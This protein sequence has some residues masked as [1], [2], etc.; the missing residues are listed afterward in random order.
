MAQ[1][2][3]DPSSPSSHDRGAAR[4]A[5]R[6]TGDTS[7]AAAL[8]GPGAAARGPYRP[9]APHSRPSPRLRSSSAACV[10]GAP[11]K[12]PTQ[13]STPDAGANARSQ[14]ALYSADSHAP[15]IRPTAPCPA[16]AAS[17]GRGAIQG[18]GA[19]KRAPACAAQR[20]AARRRASVGEVAAVLEA[21]FEGARRAGGGVGEAVGEAR[22]AWGRG[23]GSGGRRGRVEQV[24]C[25]YARR[26]RG[27][28]RP[29]ARR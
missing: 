14:P 21:I 12:V 5:A 19:H 1:C 10:H 8:R 17:A 16:V 27:A 4:I 2:R 25:G 29:L 22:A 7:H 11:S 15:Q 20:A 18:A 23:R 9:R 6:H 24:R 26:W 13:R 28:P 3:A